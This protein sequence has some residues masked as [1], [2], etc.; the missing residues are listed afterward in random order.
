PLRARGGAGLLAPALQAPAVPVPGANRD[1]PPRRARSPRPRRAGPPHDL[2]PVADL[3]RP[4]RR[5]ELRRLSP[6][7]VPGR[8][9]PRR[10]PVPRRVQLLRQPRAR[11]VAEREAPADGSRLPCAGAHERG[12][13]AAEQRPAAAAPLRDGAAL[14]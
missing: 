14:S 4:P 10:P 8:G 3:G 9:R 2:V 1:G 11:E 7:P 5:A 6:A 12:G 13:G